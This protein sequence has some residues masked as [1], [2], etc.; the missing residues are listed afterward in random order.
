V[1][2]GPDK[3]DIEPLPTTPP[4]VASDALPYDQL[5]TSELWDAWLFA[6]AESGLAL[7]AWFSARNAHKAPAFALYE[8]ALDR[9][10]QAASALATRRAAQD[11]GR[12]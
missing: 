11:A 10:D 6:E 9:E 7:A 8:A 12:S 1:P 5:H 3:T 4:V 2:S